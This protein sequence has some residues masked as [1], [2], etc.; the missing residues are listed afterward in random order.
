LIGI[1][2][3]SALSRSLGHGVVPPDEVDQAFL[4]KV[5][6]LQ[7]VGDVY[8]VAGE[9]CDGLIEALTFAD[10]CALDPFQD[11][12]DLEISQSVVTRKIGITMWEGT[13]RSNFFCHL[14]DAKGVAHHRTDRSPVHTE[15]QVIQGGK[16]HMIVIELWWRDFAV[17]VP[18]SH[19]RVV[20]SLA[21]L[22]QLDATEAEASRDCLQ[23][24]T[25]TDGHASI[26]SLL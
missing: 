14:K 19:V 9:L 6:R 18:A 25:V 4:E 24:E 20:D 21:M 26:K 7:T 13:Y 3:V 12:W 1:I 2:S 23:H 16:Q 5:S 17:F 11:G 8:P 15:I 10:E 22:V